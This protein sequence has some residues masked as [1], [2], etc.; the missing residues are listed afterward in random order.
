[1]RR[2][3]DGKIILIDFG[4][5]KEINQLIVKENGDVTTTVPIG[6]C[7]YRPSEQAK[8]KPKLC[9]DVYAVGMIG[10]QALT[11]IPPHQL[12]EDPN[13]K[14]VIWRNWVPKV[15]S[16]LADVLDKMVRDHFSQRYQNAGEALQALL[17]LSQPPGTPAPTPT[18]APTSQR[19]DFEGVTI[20][21]GVL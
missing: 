19:F 4:A 21:G 18:P 9:S 15:D 8:G 11:G 1:M 7:G 3:Q 17:F 5:V 12:P 14:E 16:R 20:D 2:R 6:T 10:I 13:T